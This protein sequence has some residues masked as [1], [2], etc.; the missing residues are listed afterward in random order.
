MRRLW[1][2]TPRLRRL[3]RAGLTDID[4]AAQVSVVD[5]HA[6]HADA[7]RFVVAAVLA[8]TALA[9]TLVHGD[10]PLVSGTKSPAPD[11]AATAPPVV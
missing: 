9:M 11:A 5:V 1:K 10:G 7:Q 6:L 4:L 8:V 2:A 3:V